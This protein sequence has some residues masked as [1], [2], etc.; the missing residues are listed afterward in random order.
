MLAIGA[1]QAMDDGNIRMIQRRQYT[2]FALKAR[3]AVIV[4]RE[5]VGQYFECDW[6]AQ[7]RI[8]GEI[9]L[10]HAARSKRIQYFVVRDPFSDHEF[11]R[12]AAFYVK[13]D[14]LVR[15]LLW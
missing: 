2:R 4:T 14:Y 13:E 9:N 10:S 3:Q 7:P 11:E 1:L 12:A 8:L 6:A 5:D 15:T